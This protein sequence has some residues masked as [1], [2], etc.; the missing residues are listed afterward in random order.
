LVETAVAAP[1]PMNS[2]G[3]QVCAVAGTEAPMKK[4]EINRIDKE[5]RIEL[6]FGLVIRHLSTRLTG[7]IET[8]SFHRIWKKESLRPSKVS[9]ACPLARDLSIL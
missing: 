2:G 5:M 4:L 9:L 3:V 8:S 6:S 1:L 7:G